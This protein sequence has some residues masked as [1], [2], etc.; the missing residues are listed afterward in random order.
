MLSGCG[1]SVRA[2]CK[3]SDSEYNKTQTDGN[4]IGLWF[5]V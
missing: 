4:D 3:D 1:Y 2:K 5:M